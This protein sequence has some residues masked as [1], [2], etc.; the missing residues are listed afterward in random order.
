MGSLIIG[1]LAFVGFLAIVL[2]VVKKIGVKDEN[3]NY[4]PDVVEEKAEE[5][6]EVVE[7]KVE[8]VVKKV[9]KPATKKKTPTTNE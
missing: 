9:R 6:K 4:I 7:E 2:V 3:N 8:E 1:L 5:I